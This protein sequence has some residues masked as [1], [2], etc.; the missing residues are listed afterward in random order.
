MTEETQTTEPTTDTKP[1][2]TPSL[3]AADVR[4]HELFLKVTGEQKSALEAR[5][6][7]LEELKASIANSKE[8]ARIKKLEEEGNYK[9]LMEEKN[10]EIA[11]I[12]ATHNSELCKMALKDEF[13]KQGCNDEYFIG[14]HLSVFVGDIKAQTEYVK[15]LREGETTVKYFGSPQQAA[16]GAKPPG[17]VSPGTR[18]TNVSLED[19]LKSDDSQTKRDALTEQLSAQIAG[20]LH[21][22]NK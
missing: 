9:Q 17:A 11:K 21:V 7:E 18:S 16:T 1:D 15:Q 8:A 19:R 6:T 20:I 10:N 22:E 3:S 4:K 12:Q 13:R 14:H 5:T 2:S